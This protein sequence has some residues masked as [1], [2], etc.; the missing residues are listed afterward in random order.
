MLKYACV[1]EKQ[2]WPQAGFAFLKVRRPGTPDGLLR[3]KAASG[4]PARVFT[5][6]ST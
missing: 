5:R 2:S 1:S 6:F 4:R 3:M